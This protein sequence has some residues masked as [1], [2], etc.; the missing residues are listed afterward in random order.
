[1][2]EKWTVADMP[3]QSGRTVVVTGANSGL[4][5]ESARAFAAKG[6]DVV[7]ACRSTARGVDAKRDIEADDPPGSLAVLE[8]DLAD[9]DSVRGFV[10]AFTG[11]Y[12]DLHVLC[13]NAGVMAIPRRETADGFEMQFGVNHLGHF[14]L[15]GL[16]LDHLRE[17]GTDGD[18]ARVATMSSGM[19]R[20]GR[21]D[22]DDLH[23]EASYDRWGAY[24]QSKLAN[25]LFAY[26]LDRRCRAAPVRGVA[27]HPGWAATNLQAR[28]PELLGSTLRKLGMKAANILLA[29]DAATGALPYLY[30]ATMPEVEGGQYYGP[31]GI[32]NMRGYPERQRS[33]RRSRDEGTAHRLWTVSEEATGVTY[34]LPAPN[35]G[36][37]AGE[38][39]ADD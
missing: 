2:S 9:L 4:G 19:H 17:T 29:Q 36:A 31:G 3:D 1:M 26:E 38:A 12:D 25:L 32:A 21:M 11:S 20:R 28:G 23:G 7:M 18:P 34:D 16:L 5:L 24:A 35:A 8:L 22:F 37:D 15:T 6:G 13:N 27:A 33:S 39:A 30:A 14:A 10:D